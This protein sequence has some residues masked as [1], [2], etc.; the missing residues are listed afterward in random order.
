[1]TDDPNLS[2]RGGGFNLFAWFKARP[3]VAIAMGAFLVISVVGILLS[4]CGG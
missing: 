3:K 1:M 2:V 4:E